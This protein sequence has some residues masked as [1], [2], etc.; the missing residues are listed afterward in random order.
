MKPLAIKVGEKIYSS[1]KV[2]GMWFSEDKMDVRVSLKVVGPLGWTIYEV[3]DLITLKDPYFYRPSS[4][5]GEIYTWIGLPSDAGPGKY[6][7]KYE[8]T[9]K[10]ANTVTNY[11]E[12]FGVE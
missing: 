9:D 3:P 11:E 1:F 7:W 6:T 8:M 10:I 12:E 5:F 4:F 2:A